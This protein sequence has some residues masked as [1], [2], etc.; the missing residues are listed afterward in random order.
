MAGSIRHW[1]WPAED[2]DKVWEKRG[3]TGHGVHLLS[4]RTEGS[5]AGRGGR[6]LTHS[7]E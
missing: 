7:L 6:L 1:L 2:E 4:T 3:R 5:R